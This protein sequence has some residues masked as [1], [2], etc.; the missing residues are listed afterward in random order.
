MGGGGAAEG[1]AVPRA[2]V[3]ELREH[4]TARSQGV[5]LRL[6][7]GTAR[8]ARW[9]ASERERQQQPWPEDAAGW[10]KRYHEDL[11]YA[12]LAARMLGEAM[13]ATATHRV[14]AGEVLQAFQERRDQADRAFAGFLARRYTE[15]VYREGLGLHRVAKEVL[16][17]ALVEQP[18]YLVVLDGCSLPVFL[19]LLFDLASADR[20]VGLADGS[21]EGPA[22]HGLLPGVAL[23]PSVTSHS[24]GA[25]FQGSVPGDPLV[26]EGLWRGGRE[27]VTDPAR[28]NACPA[29]GTHTRR[30]FL[31]GNLADG[32]QALLAALA[33]PEL[34]LVAAVFNAVDDH[35]GSHDTGSHRHFTPESIAHLVPSL[36][37]ALDRGRRVLVA[38]DHGHTLHLSKELRLGDG[39]A[40]RY[41]P[42]EPGEEPPEGT[43]VIDVGE[44]A[45][46]PAGR[47]AFCWR[48]GAYFGSLQAGYHGGC[49]L[50]ELVV[51]LA[52]LE[53][54]GVAHPA[55]P[56][57]YDR[58]VTEADRA[59]A[60]SGAGRREP[61]PPPEP[62][63]AELFSPA[64]QPARLPLPTETLERLDD[65][66]R[67]ALAAVAQRHAL[68]QT[69]LAAVLGRP[70]SRI[71]GFMAK[72]GRSL[73]AV[74][75]T[76]VAVEQ[77]PSGEQQYRWTG[78]VGNGGR[79]A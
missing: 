57:W 33:D 47:V 26:P 28:L 58:A 6:V 22:E 50:E 68:S 41:R 55:P 11:A 35:I 64:P 32:G 5:L 21:E 13:G 52:W 40:Q 2:E 8:L 61:A 15:A 72:L 74:G 42:L 17:P 69:E 62:E 45:G 66:Q 44:G 19:S 24:R 67:A 43:V 76:P 79:D 23:L 4:L 30:L 65:G 48:A 71:P 3:E 63:Q 20:A 46:L 12:D 27:A 39:K 77:L 9:L 16:A 49:S 18:C 54:G 75:G 51:P 70:A 1:E 59:A 73:A 31:K 37:V 14:E 10:C 56:W 7:A 25:L 53:R 78:P 60:P 29:L 36:E 34:D 38:A